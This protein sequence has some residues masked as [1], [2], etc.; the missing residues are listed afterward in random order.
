MT[1]TQKNENGQVVQGAR[2]EKWWRWTYEGW[3]LKLVVFISF[4]V[5][6]VFVCFVVLLFIFLLLVCL[7]SILPFFLCLLICSFFIFA[8]PSRELWSKLACSL[9]RGPKARM[10]RILGGQEAKFHVYT[11]QV[12]LPVLIIFKYKIVPPCS[13]TGCFSEIGRR[14]WGRECPVGWSFL[15]RSSHQ[16]GVD[17]LGGSLLPR[18]GRV[19]RGLILKLEFFV[20]RKK[21]IFQE[22]LE[23]DK[24]LVRLG[25]TDWM[26]QLEQE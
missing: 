19:I 20:I 21:Q 25:E 24:I 18:G 8:F 11:W 5:L 17:S 14:P 10:T 23:S 3:I 1:W 22:T 2:K 12:S 7:L 26:N 9:L 13:S 15:W 6:F 4:T 16:R